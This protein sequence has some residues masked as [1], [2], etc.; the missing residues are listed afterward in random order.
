MFEKDAD[1]GLDECTGRMRGD[2]SKQPH[3][4]KRMYS[5]ED[6]FINLKRLVQGGIFQNSF[7]TTDTTSITQYSKLNHMEHLW[8]IQQTGL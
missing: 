5:A 1:V 4:W 6:M 7:D 8:R 2:I 3:E